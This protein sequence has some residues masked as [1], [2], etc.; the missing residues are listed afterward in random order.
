MG[1]RGTRAL[2]CPDVL[3]MGTTLHLCAAAFPRVP[4]AS[5]FPATTAGGETG[6]LHWYTDRS[7]Y[8]LPKYRLGRNTLGYCI[9]GG[10]C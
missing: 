4:W 7:I 9:E 8:T 1:L 3:S 6:S 5:G 10:S 2:F